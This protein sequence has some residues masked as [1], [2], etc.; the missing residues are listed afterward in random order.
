MSPER[1]AKIL[2]LLRSG[3]TRS[4]AARAAGIDPVT[5]LRWIAKHANFAS[6]IKEVEAEAEALHVKNVEAA[7]AKGSWQA[8]AWWLERR[9]HEDWGKKERIQIIQDVKQM[10][11]D[12]GIEEAAAVQAADDILRELRSQRRA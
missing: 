3:N 5:L 10:A 11:T 2:D 7:A 6:A 8:S 1:V 9:R 4:T 12:A